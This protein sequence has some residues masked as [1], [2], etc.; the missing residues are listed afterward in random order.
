MAFRT[1]FLP[2]RDGASAED[3]LN[4]FLRTHRVLAIDRRWV[5]QGSDSF[6]VM[7]VDYLEQ[8]PAAVGVAKGAS[9][10]T[11]VD[12][13]ELL[14]TG[15][16]ELYSQLR[17]FRKEVA[18]ADGVPVYAVFNNEQLAKMVEMK[19]E[20]L[21]DLR[22]LFGVGEARVDKYGDR[23]LKRLQELRG[24]SHETSGESV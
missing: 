14:N 10:K 23:V 1:F 21:A 2:V 18:S 13:K 19:A 12:Y 15:D 20:S 22:E 24:V 11:K 16:F 6:W 17:S 3:E 4:A 5:D 8:A 9:S 7:L